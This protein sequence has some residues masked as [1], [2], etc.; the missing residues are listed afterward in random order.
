MKRRSWWTF[1]SE[2]TT[3][4]RKS[5]KSVSFALTPCHNLKRLIDRCLYPLY[6]N[7]LTGNLYSIWYDLGIDDACEQGYTHLE[8][9]NDLLESI[10]GIIRFLDR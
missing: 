3:D 8:V 4:K 7:C 2:V 6:I 1:L 9:D 10:S 5:V